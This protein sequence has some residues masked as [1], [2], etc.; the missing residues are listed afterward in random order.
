MSQ[1]ETLRRIIDAYLSE[2]DKRGLPSE[3]YGKLWFEGYEDTIYEGKI[4]CYGG[5]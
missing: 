1:S 2:V 4:G 5:V 3:A